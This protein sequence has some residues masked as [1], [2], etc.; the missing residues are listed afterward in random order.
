MKKIKINNFY[1]SN[2]HPFTL[3]A[4]PCVLEN[5]KHTFMM[6]EKLQDLSKKLK[7]NFIFKTSFD[8]ANRTSIK[9]KRGVGIKNAIKIFEEIK[10]KYNCPILT[11]IHNEEQSSM[12]SNVV[13]IIQIPAF[14]CRQ[15]DILTSAAK[16]DKIINIKKGQFLSPYEINEVINKITNKGNKKI[17]LTE[18][19]Y[20]FGYNNL[21]TDFRSIDIMK[22]TK[23][24]VIFDATHSIQEPGIR[25][26]STGGKRE[27]I[28][29]LA[30]AAVASG[31]AGLF[32][33][34]HNNPNIAPS[35]GSNMLPFKN[36]E[37]LLKI[38]IKIDRVIK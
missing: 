12:I 11:D 27:F 2:H 15:T 35:D 30:K 29:T 36:L 18:R 1:I 20:V 14:L 23:F 37:K 3:I 22:K 32:I 6:I 26:N 38:L 16:T 21:V 5:K 24:P 19:G 28:P 17:L 8:K 31:I 4:G 7:I 13:D 33:E 10:L 34:T 9:S 25:G